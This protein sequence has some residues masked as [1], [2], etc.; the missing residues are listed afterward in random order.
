MLGTEGLQYRK[1]VVKK[2]K[3]LSV[4][5]KMKVLISKYYMES[6]NIRESKVQS[7]MEEWCWKMMYDLEDF[8]PA[9]NVDLSQRTD[10]EV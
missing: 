7:E 9:D 10:E 8:G 2:H 3:I 5:F 6:K 4:V 1:M